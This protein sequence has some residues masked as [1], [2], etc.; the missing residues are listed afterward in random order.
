MAEMQGR[1]TSIASLLP[2]TEALSKL[3]YDYI[4]SAKSAS[5]IAQRILVE[6]NGFG[7]ALTALHSLPENALEPHLHASKC[8]DS[9][10]EI[11]ERY[12]AVLLDLESKFTSASRGRQR[13]VGKSMFLLL[14]ESEINNLLQTL[15]RLKPIFFQTM[16]D[17]NT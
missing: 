8:L 9:N 3:C 16:K 7:G 17:D 4:E 1:A 5:A 15:E 10:D 13:R 14:E 6:V 12:E 11:L 2:L